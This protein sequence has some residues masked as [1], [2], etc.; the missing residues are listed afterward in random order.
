[1]QLAACASQRKRLRGFFVLLF[2][3]A[4]HLI[5]NRFECR[6]VGY[7]EVGENSTVESDTGSFQAFREA[8]VGHTVSAGRGI[9]ALDP[10]ITERAFARFTVAIRPILAF[11]RRVLGVAEK[12]GAASPVT[13]G[14][15]EHALAAGA[16]GRGIACSWHFVLPRIAPGLLCQ[17]VLI[18]LSIFPTSLAD[19]SPAAAEPVERSR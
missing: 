14:F 2:Q 11:H 3:R 16:A 5:D 19:L 15:F 6:L 9:E 7:G 4:L 10:E 1:M 17:R 8:A 13:F 18:T 12:F